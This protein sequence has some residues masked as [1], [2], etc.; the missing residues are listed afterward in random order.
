MNQ[1]KGYT[2]RT[3]VDMDMTNRNDILE[4]QNISW[5]TID[6]EVERFIESQER[7]LRIKTG[8]GTKVKNKVLNVLEN[9]DTKF[10]NNK[11]EI[12]IYG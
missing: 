2:K 1:N 12:L 11:E 10:N 3:W 8:V 5:N 7:P 4:I 9:S 6:F